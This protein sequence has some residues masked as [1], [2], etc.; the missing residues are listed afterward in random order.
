MRACVHECARVCVG[1]YAD[2]RVCA[3][4]CLNVFATACMCERTS[5]DGRYDAVDCLPDQPGRHHDR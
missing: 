2:M 4:A 5:N 1:I 3:H